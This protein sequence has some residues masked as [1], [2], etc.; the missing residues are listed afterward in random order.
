MANVIDERFGA[1]LKRTREAQGLTQSDLARACGIS[2]QQVYKYE[3]GK[4]RVSISRLYDLA[5][6]LGMTVRS[7]VE[8]L[9]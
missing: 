5:D 2:F 9:R 6:A 8:D 3:T 4:N 7:L 1:R